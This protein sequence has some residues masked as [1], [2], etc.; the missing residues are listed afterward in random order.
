MS[1]VL[2]LAYGVVC[3]VAFLAAF[4]YAIWFVYTMDQKSPP[5]GSPWTTALIIDAV[6]L[7]VFAL[8]HSIMARQGFKHAWTRIIPKPIERSTYV[9]FSSLALLL[10]YLFWRPLPGVVWNVQS[11][12]LSTL[13]LILFGLGWLIVLIST[14]LIDHFELFGLK[15]VWVYFRNQS[16]EPPKFATPGFYQVVRHPIY[17]GFI[18][19][20]WA[21][22]KMTTH[23]LFFSVMTLGYILVAI[24][25]EERDLVTF[26]G[27][28]YQVYRSGVSMLVPWPRRK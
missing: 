20:F 15:Q 21:T 24:R 18:L 8:Q 5:P 19:A 11:P 6:L 4:L 28:Q 2:A 9:L 7:S 23:H 1:R 3:Y 10:M 16:F 14:F 13:L 17:L 25:L 22:P 26:H 12:F 27:E